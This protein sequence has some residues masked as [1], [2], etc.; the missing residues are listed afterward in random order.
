[1]R[2]ALI[3]VLALAACGPQ[4]P[5]S[6][7]GPGFSSYAQY[8][9]ERDAALRGGAPISSE[10]P[11][12]GLEP[13][14]GGAISATGTTPAPGAAPTAALGGNSAGISDEQS[15][16]AVTARQT[17]ESD[18]ARRQAQAAAYQQVQ[19]GALPSRPSNSGPNIVAYALAATNYKGQAI[20]KRSFPRPEAAARKCAGYPSADAAQIAFL[21]AGGPERDRK[22]LDPDGDGFACTWDP[23]PFRRATGG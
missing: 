10:V 20:Y 1:M 11:T 3:P 19:P 7:P 8:Q 9:S 17:I 16:D 5:A 6:N 13:V 2:Y 18:A 4:V 14:S 23:A 12:V 21:A 22:G 15:F